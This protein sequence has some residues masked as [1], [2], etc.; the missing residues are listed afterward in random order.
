MSRA[1]TLSLLAIATWT[2]GV[3]LATISRPDPPPP[4]A[5][6]CARSEPIESTLF[7]LGDAGGPAPAPHGADP[8][9]AE[10]VLR[11]LAAAGS[12]AVAR[13]GAEHVA[14][15]FLG[16]NVYPNG[17][18]LDPGPKRERA[19]RRLGAQIEALR[20]AGLHAWF[21][22]GNHDWSDGGADEGWA[23]VRAEGALLAAS[24]VATMA[25]PDGC[26]GPTR[27]RFGEH[28]ELLL[29][30]TAWWLYEG[31]RP[32]D[33][34]SDCAEDSEAE[35]IA[36]LGAA[37]REIAATG[38]HALVMAHHPLASGGPH[39]GR[40]NW[41]EHLFPL[42]AIDARLWLPL[43]VLGSLY[44]VSRNLGVSPQD[45]SHPRYRALRSALESALATAP[46]LVYAAGHDHGLQLLRGDHARWL[47]V[48]GAGSSRQITFARPTAQTLFADAVPGFARLDIR[49]GG[50][51]ELR[52]LATPTDAAPA[53][54][55]SACLKE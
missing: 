47:V 9:A 39:A 34:D 35:I 4:V 46:P 27:I 29:L 54:V 7:L 2:L 16:D 33:P 30:D 44:P 18:P 53:T 1:R 22:P 21:V 13:L 19:E 45:F 3:V 38:R 23:R 6:H 24:G 55:F 5:P 26:P 20:R 51:V 17:V 11:A 37:L 42:R 48:S 32:S 52:F 14:A 12:E 43:P 36:A 50:S 49:R 40:F 10:P 25:P 8:V 41:L 28:V 15:V 31:T